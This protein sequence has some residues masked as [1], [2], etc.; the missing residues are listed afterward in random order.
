MAALNSF[1]GVFLT[2]LICILNT[3]LPLGEE[4]GLRHGLS[5]SLR[6]HN[7][8]ASFA[9]AKCEVKDTAIPKKLV[10][11]LALVTSLMLVENIVF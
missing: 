10:N 9:F 4:H 2:L 6:K 7:L 11:A 8:Y 5:N 3:F 1:L